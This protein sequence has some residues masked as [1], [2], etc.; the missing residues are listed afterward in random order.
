M[1]TTEDKGSV[2]VHTT[3]LTTP[4]DAEIVRIDMRG[5]NEHRFRIRPHIEGLSGIE[6]RISI[7]RAAHY[8]QQ[9]FHDGEGIYIFKLGWGA[10][11]L[12][13]TNGEFVVN[14]GFAKDLHKFFVI[15]PAA[16]WYALYLSGPAAYMYGA[17]SDETGGIREYA[18]PLP[19]ES[20][21][22]RLYGTQH[23]LS[24]HEIAELIS[25]SFSR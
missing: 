1:I 10:V 24:S 8:Q 15:A 12:R 22:L 6:G 5:G 9:K 18:F 16:T 25:K 3:T 17:G 23:G 4:I 14:M 20:E 11:L 2:I 7:S 19:D 21:L 13:R